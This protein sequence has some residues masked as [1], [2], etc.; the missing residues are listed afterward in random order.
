[1]IIPDRLN[2]RWIATLENQQLVDAETFL[3]TEF[4]TREAAEKLRAGAR[5]STLNGPSTLVNAWHRWLLV[6]NAVRSRGIVVSR[7]RVA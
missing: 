2:A 7:A 1:M 3:H 5:Y 6:S 4:A